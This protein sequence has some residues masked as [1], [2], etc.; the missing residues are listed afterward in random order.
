MADAQTFRHRGRHVFDRL[1]VKQFEGYIGSPG[2][3]RTFFVDMNNG[4][5][6]Y[7][8]DYPSSPKAT[9]AGAMAR[10]TTGRDDSQ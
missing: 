3:G 5:D 2:N 7:K 10:C 1:A 9:I 4:D 8:G 6:D